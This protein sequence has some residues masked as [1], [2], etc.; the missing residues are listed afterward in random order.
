M[1]IP[2][3]GSAAPPEVPTTIDISDPVAHVHYN[4]N[5]Q[6]KTVNRQEMG[7]A[8]LNGWTMVNT[9][10]QA[11][12]VP[13]IQGRLSTV[14]PVTNAAQSD[15]SRPQFKTEKLDPETIEGIAAE[16]SRTTVTYPVG[17]VGNDREIVTTNEVWTSRELGVMVLSKNFDPRNGEQTQKLTNIS[18]DDPDPS[19]FQPP[20]GYEIVDQNNQPGGRM[21]SVLPT[22]R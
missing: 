4:F 2:M 8:P 17:S 7:T 19:L 11:T 5:T 20:A 18:R 12:A 15:P 21:G 3:M 1:R 22:G 13:T 6:S 16:G 10:G 14:L 9:N